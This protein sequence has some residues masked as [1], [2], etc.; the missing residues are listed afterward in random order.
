MFA[1]DPPAVD[2]EISTLSGDALRDAADLLEEQHYLGA[3]RPVGRTLVQAV[4]PHGRW[5]ALLVWGL[6]ALKLADRDES[7]GW[8]D[9]QRAER[10]GLVVQNRRFLVL[11]KTR[12]P[13][14]ASR[15][16]GLAVNALS[17]A[18]ERLHGFRPL[19]A[20][21]FTDIEQ[22]EGTCYKA[23]G[24]PV[25]LPRGSPANTAPTLMCAT[26]VPR[27]SGCAPSTATPVPLLRAIDIAP[28]YEAGINR[29]R[30]ERALPLRKGQFDSLREVL[31]EVPDPRARNQVFTC[32]SLLVL[33]ANLKHAVDVAA[34]RPPFT[35]ESDELNHG[36][37]EQRVYKVYAI[38]AMGV[39]YVRTLVVRE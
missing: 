27:S 32:S 9:S 14:L 8:T 22:F 30:P 19:L 37:K 28:G 5:V 12:M 25:A 6:A 11:A 7:I 17:E 20:E 13:N 16:L 23:A 1:G 24:W 15:A 3:G 35:C 2:L 18:W 38:E 26:A 31:R 4:H 36:R 21:T 39:D 34:K 29:Q 33:V 10:I